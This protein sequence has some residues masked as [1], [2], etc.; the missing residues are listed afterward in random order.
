MENGK[1]VEISDNAMALERCFALRN[2]LKDRLPETFW[3]LFPSYIILGGGARYIL[4][5]LGIFERRLETPFGG[6][7]EMEGGPERHHVVPKLLLGKRRIEREED[8]RMTVNLSA[9]EHIA[10]H[11]LMWWA[12]VA[13]HGDPET[14]K[15]AWK[16]VENMAGRPGKDEILKLMGLKKDAV[17]GYLSRR[18]GLRR[19]YSVEEM[20]RFGRAYGELGFQEAVRLGWKGSERALRIRLGEF[21]P[22]AW[23]KGE[24]ERRSGRSSGEGR[25]SASSECSS[26]PSLRDHS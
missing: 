15:G 2:R 10:V 11:C 9:Y 24:P 3:S 26:S 13:A 7:S 20:E 17:L 4:N 22:G 16:C 6:Y 23:G 18:R 5:I 25:S 21:F 1:T 14:I 8:L 12:L 19:R